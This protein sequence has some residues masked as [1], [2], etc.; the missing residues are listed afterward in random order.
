VPE[1]FLFR[2]DLAKAREYI[3][4]NCQLQSIISLPQGVF[5]PYTGVKTN[6]IYATKVNQKLKSADKRKDYWYFDVKSD[7]YTLDSHR[8]KLDSS[9]DLST[10]EEYRKLDDEQKDEMLQVGFDIIPLD[11]VRDNSY[12]LVG[13]KYREQE[14]ILSNYDVVTLGDVAEYINGFPFK[15]TDWTE[16]GTPIIRIQNLTNTSKTANRTLKNDVPEKHKV[17]NGDL[18]IS[19]S[20]TIGFYI[21]NGDNAYLNQHIFKVI[22]NNRILK[23]IYIS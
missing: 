10:Y 21:W 11:K 22:P 13:S 16:N 1:G 5:L 3:L 9:S 2:K 23:N 14:S 4:E 18:L 12:V 7:G 20:A 17:E 15:P 6:I 19:W 8:R